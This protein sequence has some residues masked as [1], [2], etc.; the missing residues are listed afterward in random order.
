MY[1]IQIYLFSVYVLTDIRILNNI[2]VPLMTTVIYFRSPLK[3][4]RNKN[5]RPKLPK[6]LM[7]R[8]IADIRKRILTR[9]YGIIYLKK[10]FGV[11]YPSECKRYYDKKLLTKFFKILKGYC[12]E[13]KVVNRLLNKANIFF[14]EKLIRKSFIAWRFYTVQAKTIKKQVCIVKYN[15]NGRL[16]KTILFNWRTA[17]SDRKKSKLIRKNVIE[18]YHSM[19]VL[20]LMLKLAKHFYDEIECNLVEIKSFICGRYIELRE[21]IRRWKLFMFQQVVKR[22]FFFHIFKSHYLILIKIPKKFIAI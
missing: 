5:L 11:Y 3:Y 17:T 20:M 7:N 22:N 12:F 2:A 21:Y 13:G 19:H 9:K 4:V 1:C 15:R 18:L 8:K 14:K 16:L 6:Y 10:I